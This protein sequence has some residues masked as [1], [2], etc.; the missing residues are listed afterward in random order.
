MK[1]SSSPMRRYSTIGLYVFLLFGVLV[2]TANAASTLTRTSSFT[3]H[4][5]NGLLLKEIVEPDNSTLCVVTEYVYDTFGN[6]T[7]STV[8][9]C[10]KSTGEA[11]APTGDA[12]V[13]NRVSTNAYDS[14]GQFAIESSNALKQSESRSFD[15][16]FGSLTQLVGPNGLATNWTYDG[17][18]R[19][20]SET[21]SDG[22]VTTWA[23]A[24]CSGCGDL[25]NASYTIT[26]TT[27]GAPAS[28]VYYDGLDRPI[29]EQSVGFDGVSIINVDTVYDDL[30]RVSQ[31]SKPYYAGQNIY[32]A[33]FSYDSLGRVVTETSPEG[34][35]TTIQYS[36]LSTRVTNAK[37]QTEAKV[38]NARGQLVSVTNALGNTLTYSYDPSGNL[39]TTTDPKGNVTTLTY[40]LKGRKTAMADPDMG[41]W[42]Y[43]YDALGQLVGQTDAKGQISTIAYDLLGRVIKRSEPDLVSNWYYDKKSD[44]TP[45]GKSIG[46]LCEAKADNGYRRVHSYDML[47]RPDSTATTLDATYV[48]SVSYDSLGR[49]ATKTWPTGFAVKYQYTSLGYLQAI[50][51]NS[52]DSLY[53]QANT[54]DAEGHLLSQT[55]G[56]NVLTQRT[57]N[58]AGG[59]LTGILAGAGNGVQNLSYS[60]DV[61]GNLSSRQDNVTTSQESFTYDDLNRLTTYSLQGPGASGIVTRTVSY[62]SIGN[63]TAKSDAG[64]YFYAPNTPVHAATGV[65][66]GAAK[67][68]AFTYDKNGN[69]IYTAINN[70]G[71]GQTVVRTETYTSYNMPNNLTQTVPGQSGNISIGFVYGPEHQRT[72]QVS[73]V[74]GTT[75]Y[76]N[77]PDSQG[78]EFEKDVKS[79]GTE[80]KHYISAGGQVVA[81]YT[82]NSNGTQSLRYFHYDHLGSNSVITDEAG[83]VLERLAYDPWGKRQYA[84]AGIAPDGYSPVS[85][86][87]GFTMHEHLDEMGI[88]HMNGRVYDPTLG[89]FMSADPYIQAPDNLLS[90]NRYAYC[91]G[92]PLVCVDPSG[93]NWWSKNITKPFAKA[94]N[95]PVVRLVVT[96]AVAY[97]TGYYMDGV[98]ASAGLSGTSLSIANGAASGF[99]G[100][101]VGSGGN[102]RAAV[103]GGLTGG[104]FGY[105]GSLGL[106]GAQAI[107]AH[108]AVGCLSASISGG[109]CQSGAL[110]AG[111]GKLATINMPGFVSGNRAFEMAYVSVAGGTASVLGGGKF[112]NGAQTAAFG[113][114]FNYCMH[115]TTGCWIQ[116]GMNALKIVG[117]SASFAVGMATCG[118]TFGL[119]CA[120]A[121]ESGNQVIEGATYFTTPGAEEGFKPSKAVLRSAFG[122]DMGAHIN[123]GLE[124]G[125]ALQNAGA[126]VALKGFHLFR[127]DMSTRI[128][129]MGA[130]Q[131]GIAAGST[132]GK[133]L[134]DPYYKDQLR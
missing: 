96:V 25:V 127:P 95:N 19:K 37:G 116:K 110:S 104:A 56:N 91:I 115:S 36:G 5:S 82:T 52:D 34:T 103:A 83:V 93:Y 109:D 21:R 33:R 50:R 77:S 134:N 65:T 17:F 57:Y 6:K 122:N 111:F 118:A 126:P 59:Q 102:L 84:N 2:T 48:G 30:G 28:V 35:K 45:C 53:W 120:A 105:V 128:E 18:G 55:Q 101:Y 106:A 61:L 58:P 20:T 123:T 4:P 60:Y 99:A 10:N 68:Y 16:R 70:P 108:A 29:R 114:L 100:S 43:R 13:S 89:L 31:K 69:L 117:G 71:T 64:N 14:R 130:A 85:T 78:L 107:G 32:W 42:L 12:V 88:V 1:S 66:G 76:L 92:N 47:G 133:L 80:N 49:L 113:Y 87:R 51:N 131:L 63:I 23:Y 129:Q 125:T 44:G 3:Y 38:K 98:F 9:N 67:T 22:T 46:K 24:M 74:N 41:T 90:Y 15:A 119:G 26:T 81:L 79:S 72:K 97:F 124:V 62:D 7:S 94:M 132:A 86:D 112:A 75:F 27:T 40:D 73:S 39:L 121:V 11:A 54:R 8:R